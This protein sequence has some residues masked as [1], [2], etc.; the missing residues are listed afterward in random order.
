MVRSNSRFNE[1]EMNEPVVELED[2]NDQSY[3]E[4]MDIFDEGN[5]ININ[6]LL[7]DNLFHQ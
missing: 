3:I 1:S 5:L 6:A 4:F 7:F 2:L